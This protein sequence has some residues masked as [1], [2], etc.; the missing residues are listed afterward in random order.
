M[1]RGAYLTG[2]LIV[3]HPPAGVQWRTSRLRRWGQSASAWSRARDDSSLRCHSSN[4]SLARDLAHAE[5]GTEFIDCGGE[6]WTRRF[7]H[8]RLYRAVGKKSEA[9]PSERIG[10][11]RADVR[12]RKH[13]VM[14]RTARRAV[15]ARRRRTGR[16][17]W[18]S[19]GPLRVERGEEVGAVRI[20]HADRQDV[21][22]VLSAD[23]L[24]DPARIDERAETISPLIERDQQ[25]RPPGVVMHGPRDARLP[26]STQRREIRSHPGRPVMAL[27]KRQSVGRQHG[28]Q[29][30]AGG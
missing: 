6:R 20:R 30:A 29:H 2:A 28:P 17:R 7:E 19:D 5:V 26:A 11:L 3:V 15:A 13:V 23:C 25:A 21:A 9:R 10:K 22:S 18:S 16:F 24:G 1:P 4:E 12:R 27:D 14:Q 8:V